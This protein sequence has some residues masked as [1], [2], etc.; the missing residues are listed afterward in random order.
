MK[1]QYRD[2][3]GNL[4]TLRKDPTREVKLANGQRRALW[5]EHVATN[6]WGNVMALMVYYGGAWHKI[7]E[8]IVCDC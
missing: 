7:G 1:R 6:P 2:V 5:L 4:R 3:W 8:E